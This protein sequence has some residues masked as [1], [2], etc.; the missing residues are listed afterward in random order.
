MLHIT[1]RFVCLYV[2]MVVEAKVAAEIVHNSGIT[3]T[4]NGVVNDAA[5]AFV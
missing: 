1:C 2:G 3:T 5:N 4:M